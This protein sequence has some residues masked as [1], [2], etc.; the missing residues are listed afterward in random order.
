MENQG[1]Q[2]KINIVVYRWNTPI[3]LM[4]SIRTSTNAII[5]Y[6]KSFLRVHFKCHNPKEKQSL[7]EEV[8][9]PN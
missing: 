4:N 1:I 8:A 2:I 9:W 3:D 5:L 6:T 7:H